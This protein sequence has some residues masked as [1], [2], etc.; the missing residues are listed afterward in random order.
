V[1]KTLE[2]NCAMKISQ[3]DHKQKLIILYFAVIILRLSSQIT[4]N[5]SFVSDCQCQCYCRSVGKLRGLH[6]NTIGQNVKKLHF[7]DFSLCRCHIVVVNSPILVASH[8]NVAE[9]TAQRQ[10]TAWLVLGAQHPTLPCPSSDGW[11]INELWRIAYSVQRQWRLTR[12][13][14]RRPYLYLFY[15]SSRTRSTHTK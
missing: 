4:E 5:V 3:H 9:C 8:L 1:V 11:K 12:L 15:Y 7:F 10:H 13:H 2:N 6:R 14:K